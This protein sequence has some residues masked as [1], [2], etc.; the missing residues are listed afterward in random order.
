MAKH[1]TG[2]VRKTLR[3]G[4]GHLALR[5]GWKVYIDLG[6]NE[7]IY[8]YDHPVGSNPRNLLYTFNPEQ[9][10]LAREHLV[11]IKDK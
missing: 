2:R 4:S 7:T 10:E 6:K 9:K 11:L 3:F 1:R 8:V 5:A